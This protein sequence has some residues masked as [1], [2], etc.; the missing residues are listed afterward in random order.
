DSW[1]DI[2]AADWEVLKRWAP[3]TW[4]REAPPIQKAPTPKAQSWRKL[5]CRRR[6]SCRLR[7]TQ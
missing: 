4:K 7:Q 5:F 2:A 3:S 6:L 1:F